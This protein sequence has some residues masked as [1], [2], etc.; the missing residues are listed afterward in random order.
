MA[1]LFKQRSTL[2]S[3]T[4][5]IQD[6]KQDVQLIHD[7][8]SLAVTLTI[9]FPASPVDGQIFGVTSTLGV[10]TLTLTSAITIVNALTALVAGGFAR[11]IYDAASNKWFRIG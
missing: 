1:D 6:T 8:A 7:A 2:T 5:P 10:T 9:T 11:W 4:I 3:G